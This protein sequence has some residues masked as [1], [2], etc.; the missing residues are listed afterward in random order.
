[1]AHHPSAKKRIRQAAKRTEVNRSRTSSDPHL[2]QEG[3]ASASE[4]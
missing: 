1:M 4:R 2:H 3:R